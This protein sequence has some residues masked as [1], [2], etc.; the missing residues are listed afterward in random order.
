MT[1]PASSGRP[2]I[3][4]VVFDYGHTLMGFEYIREQLEVGYEGIARYLA[5]N[6]GRPVP[7]GADLVDSVSR[8]LEERIRQ[9]YATGNPREMDIVTAY[10]ECFA[11]AG[12]DLDVDTVHGVMDLEQATWNRIVQLSPHTRPLLEHLREDLGLPVGICSNA[13]FLGRHMRSQLSHFEVDRWIDCAVFS[14]E[15][16]WRKPHEAM[17]QTVLAGLGVSPSQALYVGDR[18]REDVFGPAAMGMTTVLTHE[19]R[20]ELPVDAI[21]PDYV[22]SSLAELPGILRNLMEGAA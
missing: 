22:V 4:A 5:A 15:V 3:G 1:N 12:I 21:R 17:Y 2:P 8:P 16:G 6:L 20:K 18:L 7:P 9:D 13:A 11:G 14:S 19:F 10:R